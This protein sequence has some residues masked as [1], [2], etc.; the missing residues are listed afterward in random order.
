MSIQKNK[1]HS[2]TGSSHANNHL[3]KAFLESGSIVNKKIDA[4]THSYYYL[5]DDDDYATLG[6]NISEYTLPKTENVSSPSKGEKS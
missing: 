6:R 1:T 4:I 2:G 3:R 5:F